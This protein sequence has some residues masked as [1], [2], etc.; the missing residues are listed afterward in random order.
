[1]DGCENGN[2]FHEMNVYTVTLAYSLASP[3]G[4]MLTLKVV[5]ELIRSRS[6]KCAYLD[7]P[8]HI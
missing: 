3:M 1:M 4:A 6:L 8:G 2:G 5:K 7:I